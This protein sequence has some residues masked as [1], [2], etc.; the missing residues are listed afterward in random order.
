VNYILATVRHETAG[1]YLPIEERG[2]NAYLIKRYWE[3]TRLRAALGNTCPEDAIDYK[4]KG[5]VQ[6]TGRGNSRRV[7][8]HIGHDLE[9]N[10]DLP[11]DPTV[12]YEIMVEGM[13][14]GL[15][16]GKCL[17]DYTEGVWLDTVEAR[18]I[19]NGTDKAKL[20]AQYA[21]EEGV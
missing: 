11:L 6:I 19:I 4:G 14:H 21:H 15:F 7:G 12:A 2:S 16:T 1:T 5:Y 20:I 17:E 9:G 18:R 3:N 13:T 10:P 8:K